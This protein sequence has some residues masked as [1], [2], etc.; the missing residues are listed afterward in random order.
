MLVDVVAAGANE[1][2]SVDFDVIAK[3]ELRAEDRRKAVAAARAKADLYAEADPALLR[4][5]APALGLHTADLFVIA[6]HDLPADLAPAGGTRPWHGGQVLLSAMRLHGERFDRLHEFIRSVPGRDPVA[7]LPVPRSLAEPG[8]LVGGL[9]SNRNIR[10]HIAKLP[11]RARLAALAW[12]ARRLD[13]EQLSQVQ[14]LA[15]DLARVGSGG[16]TPDSITRGQQ[17]HE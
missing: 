15:S 5:L 10:P 14:H 8:A 3:R 12:D 2:E 17:R 4:R 9:L 6:G 11:R 13:N 7:P 16:V 1:I